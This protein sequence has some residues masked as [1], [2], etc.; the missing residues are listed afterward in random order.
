MMPAIPPQTERRIDSVRNWSPM[1]VWVGPN[2]DRRSGAIVIEERFG[3]READQDRPIDLGRA[4]HIVEDADDGEPLATDVDP[5]RRVEAID[6]ETL[7]SHRPQNG[8]RVVGG[9]VVEE[10][11]VAHGPAEDAQ[12]IGTRRIDRD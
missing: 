8:G 11:A 6:A 10:H 1:W 7:R 9:R 12:Q 5:N 4:G 3:D 2:V